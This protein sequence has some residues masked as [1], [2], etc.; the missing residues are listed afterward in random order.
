MFDCTSRM[1]YK[2]TPNFYRDVRRVAEHVPMVLV[3][4]KCDC[5]GRKCVARP[6]GVCAA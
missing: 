4:N 3:G 2:H 1:S 6:H 5:E